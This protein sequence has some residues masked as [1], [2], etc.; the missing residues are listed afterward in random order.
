MYTIGQVSKMFNIP[1]STL[2]YYD[3]EGLFPSIKRE[4]NIRK[5]DDSELETL[6]II[7]CLKKSGMEIKD[8]RRYMELCSK[9]NSTYPERKALFDKQRES[10]ENEIKRLEKTLDMLKFKCWYYDRAIADG[11]EEHIKKMLPDKLPADIQ[12]VYDHAHEK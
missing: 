2:R 9:G 7:D 5:F 8:I 6:R 4:S 1:V 3:K 11:N 12:A 10:V